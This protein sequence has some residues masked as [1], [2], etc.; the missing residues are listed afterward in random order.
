[1]TTRGAAPE[2]I[3]LQPLRHL[4][5]KLPLLD[6]A[7]RKCRA[8]RNSS[9]DADPSWPSGSASA[10][11]EPLWSSGACSSRSQKSTV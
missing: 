6:I 2:V 5:A 9:P 4:F 11:S 8:V 1:M 7:W 3:D 10:L